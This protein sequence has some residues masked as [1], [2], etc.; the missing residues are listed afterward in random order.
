MIGE[1]DGFY[2]F[3]ANTISNW[4]HAVVVYH[5]VGQG[6]TVYFDGNK[7]FNCNSKNKGIYRNRKR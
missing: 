6:M 2:I 1:T 3:L 4:V 7:V 5:G